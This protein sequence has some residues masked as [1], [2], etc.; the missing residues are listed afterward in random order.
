MCH[1]IFFLLNFNQLFHLLTLKYSHIVQ[2]DYQGNF[3]G[4]KILWKF[5]ILRVILCRIERTHFLV[6]LS[7]H[8]VVGMVRLSVNQMVE[9]ITIQILWKALTKVK[10][11]NTIRV[12]LETF[13]LTVLLL[14]IKKA[15]PAS[16]A[17]LFYEN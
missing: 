15:M 6:A 1:A 5:F 13:F 14:I 3:S 9:F 17:W 7:G 8:K 11:V 10:R 12:P 2:I 16:P 4:Q